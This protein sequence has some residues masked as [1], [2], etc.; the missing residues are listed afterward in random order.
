MKE[1]LLSIRRDPKKKD[2]EEEFRNAFHGRNHIWQPNK[3]QAA[4][5]LIDKETSI[6]WES[7]STSKRGNTKPMWNSHLPHPEIAYHFA[8]EGDATVFW[9]KEIVS[10]LEAWEM[11]KSIWNETMEEASINANNKLRKLGI[12]LRIYP[13]LQWQ[14]TSEGKFFD[15]PE[16]KRRER[17]VLRFYD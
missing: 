3:S 9:G 13:R 1:I 8:N 14:N 11:A 6:S 7:K 10:S 5:D 16:R 12:P 4:P 2:T 15:H 17:E